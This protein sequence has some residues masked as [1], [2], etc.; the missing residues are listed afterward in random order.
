MSLYSM[1]ILDVMMLLVVIILNI[2]IW[3]ELTLCKLTECVLVLLEFCNF[4]QSVE[5]ALLL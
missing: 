1:F 5:K 3:L 4:G 2:K